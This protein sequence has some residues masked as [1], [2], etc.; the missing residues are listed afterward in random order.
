MMIPEHVR[1]LVIGRCD[2]SVL[3]T[4]ANWI[5]ARENIRKTLVVL[6]ERSSFGRIK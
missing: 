5:D 2:L 4:R 3:R 6:E 1:F